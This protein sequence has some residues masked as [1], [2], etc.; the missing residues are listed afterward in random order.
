MTLYTVLSTD[1]PHSISHCFRDKWILHFTQELKM[2]AK[3]G[4]NMILCKKWQMTLW[5]K[6]FIVITSCTT[7]KMNVFL[8]FTKKLKMAM[9]ND[10]KMIFG[11][12]WQM[13][14]YNLEVKKIH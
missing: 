9:K 5:T 8:Q 10:R 7:S 3:N 12:K 14:A 13:T 1:F 6:N 2:A 4:R 11:K